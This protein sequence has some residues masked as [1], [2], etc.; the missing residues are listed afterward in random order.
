VW[1]GREVT[2]ALGSRRLGRALRTGT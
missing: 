2:D 1:D